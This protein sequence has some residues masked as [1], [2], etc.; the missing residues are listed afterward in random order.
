[1]I[2][3]Q[4]IEM[5]LAHRWITPA[6][7]VMQ[8]DKYSRDL[9]FTLAQNGQAWAVPEGATAVIRY[10]KP[11]GTGGNYDLMPDG[12]A[13]YTIAGNSVTVKLAPQV[14][15]VPGAVKL[16]VGLI[17]GES[18]LH[19]FTVEILVQANPGLQVTSEN[20]FKVAGALADS[21]WEPNMYLGTDENGNVVAKA[22]PAG[23]GGTGMTEEQAAQ[24]EANTAAITKLEADVQAN[25]DDIDAIPV[26]VAGDGYTDITG[27]RQ[28]TSIRVVRSG[29]TVTVT[30]T[31]EGGGTH[32][33]AIT[34]D[35]NDYPLT[36]VSDGVE[37]AV[38]WEGF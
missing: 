26:T 1:M 38:S 12:S 33:D 16:T 14:L 21:G 31:L 29:L 17:Q 11:D 9:E 37:C 19:T 36:V 5:D 35:D 27:L 24:L 22:A 20:Y 10:R 34:L 6:V 32:T 18:Q 4:K 13:A 30:T 2:V 28:P 23:G 15:T 7:S 8:D 25:R 3:T